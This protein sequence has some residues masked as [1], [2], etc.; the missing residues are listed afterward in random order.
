MFTIDDL[1]NFRQLNSHTP[2]HPEI[3]MTHGVDASSGPLGQV[4]Q[5]QLEWQ[6]LKNF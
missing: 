1:K 4:F 5:W 2:G 3:E 6:W